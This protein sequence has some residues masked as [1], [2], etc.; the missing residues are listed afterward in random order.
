M[1][2][3]QTKST[4]TK[5]RKKTKRNQTKY[6]N[7]KKE[8]TLKSRQDFLETEYVDGVYDKE[9][10][11]V[12]RGLNDEEQE[13]LNKFYKETLSASFGHD[14]PLIDSQ[15]GR[16]ECYNA[17]NARNRDIYNRKKTTKMLNP[18]DNES[19]DY[20]HQNML[21]HQKEIEDYLDEAIDS[22]WKEEIEERAQKEYDEKEKK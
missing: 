4:K 6:P 14:D 12:I 2:N 20:A 1:P 16:K 13:W 22:H 18:I 3:T 10:K 7:L 11:Q 15:E 19:Y 9:G 8:L 5:G 21:N 17:N